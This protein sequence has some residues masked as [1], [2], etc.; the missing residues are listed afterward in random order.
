MK[1][2][3]KNFEAPED[4]NM[5]AIFYDN[6]PFREAL[7][8]DKTEI[9]IDGEYEIIGPSYYHFEALILHSGEITQ[10]KTGV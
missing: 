8:T 2:K 4:E 1:E 10:Y 5:V 9:E 7:D 3:V 6:K